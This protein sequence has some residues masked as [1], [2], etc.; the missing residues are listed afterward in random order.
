MEAIANS[1]ED[2]LIDGL[3]FKL[4]NSA[5]YITER[6]SVTFQATGSNIYTGS[7]A[8]T[9]VIKFQLNSDGWCDPST[10]RVMFNL[11]NNDSAGEML[12][13]LQGPA[14]F[15]RRLRISAKNALIEDISEY[16]R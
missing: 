16:N 3:S 8:G 14:S 4:G 2:L 5:S 7:G 6:K 9:K 13:T 1:S 12:R 15:F 10:V 11:E